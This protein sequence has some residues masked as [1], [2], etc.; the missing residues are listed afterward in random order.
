[1]ARPPMKRI[2]T[3]NINEYA[4]IDVM[5]APGLW[6]VVYD[7][8]FINVKYIL[9]KYHGET[10]KYIKLGFPNEKPAENLAKKLNTSFKTDKFTVK[11]VI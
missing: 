5:A 3:T 1:M 6:F 4:S 7:N 8:Q 11:K 2:L 10:R 9:L